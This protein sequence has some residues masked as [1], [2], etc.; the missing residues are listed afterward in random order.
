MAT[1]KRAC[2]WPVRCM[3]SST[4]YGSISALAERLL[5]LLQ[6]AGGAG[7]HC[8]ARQSVGDRGQSHFMGRRSGRSAR[9]GRR[10]FGDLSSIGRCAPV[11]RTASI[12]WEPSCACMDDYETGRPQVLESLRLYR[13]LGDQAGHRHRPARSGR[14]RRQQR[15]ERACAYLQEG[16]AIFRERGDLIGIAY[17]LSDLGM[18]SLRAGR[19]RRRRSAGWKKVCTC[20]ARSADPIR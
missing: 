9:A 10:E 14:H 1:S 8:A 18:L 2:G 20:K 5:Q 7:A 11:K 13:Q 4:R 17:A 15:C 3:S 19:V 12:R 6:A 16:L